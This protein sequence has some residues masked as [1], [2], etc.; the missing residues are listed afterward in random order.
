MKKLTNKILIISGC[1]ILFAN[2]I[3][4][5]IIT[6]GGSNSSIYKF[7]FEMPKIQQNDSIMN[8]M[9]IQISDVDSSKIEIKYDSIE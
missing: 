7:L 3:T 1:V 6:R 9:N 5:T 2:F 8:Q 4:A